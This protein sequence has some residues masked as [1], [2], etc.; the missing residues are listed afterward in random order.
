MN[1]FGWN[2]EQ[3]EP[4]VGGWPWQI[5]GMIRTLATVWETA[6]NFFGHSN[7]AQFPFPIGQILQHLNKQR[8]SVRRWKLYEQ[9]FTKNCSKKFPG[10]ATSCR[11]NSAIIT[12]RR[13]FRAKLTIY[14]MSSFIFTVRINA[15][16]F[17]WAVCSIQ[18]RYLPKFFATSD[19]RH[20]V[21]KPIVHRSAGAA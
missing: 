5:L 20:C 17:L 2:L 1:L 10:L 18:E 15:K 8:R 19:V 16:S 12:D 14:V 4:N 6:K 21:L 7:N 3:R 11:H 13:K 9:N